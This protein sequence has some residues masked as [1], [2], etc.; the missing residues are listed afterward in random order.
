MSRGDWTCVRGSTMPVR[1]PLDRGTL[2][3]IFTYLFLFCAPLLLFVFLLISILYLSGQ[4][5]MGANKTKAFCNNKSTS[6]QINPSWHKNIL[7]NALVLNTVKTTLTREHLL[8]TWC[9][10][11]PSNFGRTIIFHKGNFFK[12]Y[13]DKYN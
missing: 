4:N 2:L 1:F 9:L 13:T 3:F 6:N 12:L 10:I 5:K 8:S 11:S 7:Y